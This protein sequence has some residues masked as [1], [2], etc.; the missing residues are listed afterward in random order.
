MILIEYYWKFQEKN[1]IDGLLLTYPT[2]FKTSNN[3]FVKNYFSAYF[4]G[5]SGEPPLESPLLHVSSNMISL[6]S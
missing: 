6:S 4:I 3:L 5:E 1:C 2:G